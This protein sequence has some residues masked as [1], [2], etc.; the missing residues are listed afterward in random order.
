MSYNIKDLSLS[1]M[2]ELVDDCIIGDE[3][4]SSLPMNIPVLD[5]LDIGEVFLSNDVYDFLEENW[6]VRCYSKFITEG[7]YDISIGNLKLNIYIFDP[8]EEPIQI[9]YEIDRNDR[10]FPGYYITKQLNGIY[11]M[12][13]YL[14]KDRVFFRDLYTDE[15]AHIRH[16]SEVNL[17]KGWYLVYRDLKIVREDKI[18]DRV[19]RYN[20]RRS[21]QETDL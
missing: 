12:Y 8:C 14:E 11:D 9:P 6:Y 21:K 5:V 18:N 13:L 2:F 7:T 17:C 4:N 19:Q 1:K 10:S 3:P 20:L 16:Q 15:M